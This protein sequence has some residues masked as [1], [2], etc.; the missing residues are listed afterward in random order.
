MSKYPSVKCEEC[1]EPFTQ[2]RVDKQFCSGRCRS[3]SF[4][5]AQKEKLSVIEKL[6]DQYVPKR[7]KDDL[8]AA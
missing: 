4:R 1:E 7:I 6:F 3:R 5:R 8:F 2:N